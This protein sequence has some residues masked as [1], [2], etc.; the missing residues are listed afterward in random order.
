MLDSTS[1]KNGEENPASMGKNFRLK[2]LK[3]NI[4]MHSVIKF[5]VQNVY[6]EIIN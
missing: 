6:K 5:S 1:Y 4:M 2:T 3:K